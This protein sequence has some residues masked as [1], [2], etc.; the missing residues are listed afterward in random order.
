MSGTFALENP[1]N[2]VENHTNNLLFAAIFTL[3]LSPSSANP[4]KQ[5][6]SR[7]RIKVLHKP[8]TAHCDGAHIH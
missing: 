6:D 3:F 4:S 2:F 1:N 5:N 8:A 7:H